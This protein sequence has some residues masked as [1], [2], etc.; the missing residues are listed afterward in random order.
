MMVSNAQQQQINQVRID[1]EM[2]HRKLLADNTQRNQ[3]FANFVGGFDAGD[4]T[5]PATRDLQRLHRRAATTSAALA[6]SNPSTAH[7]TVGGYAEN[8]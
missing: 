8:A 6:Y 7:S 1:A 4:G 5:T 2:Y 3:D